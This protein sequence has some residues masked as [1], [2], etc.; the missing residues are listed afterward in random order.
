MFLSTRKSV[1]CTTVSLT[2]LHLLLWKV[3]TVVMKRWVLCL[4][5]G[6]L[7]SNGSFSSRATDTRCLLK[8]CSLWLKR[9]RLIPSLNFRISQRHFPFTASQV[10]LR[11]YMAFSS[12]HEIQKIPKILRY[13]AETSA[14]GKWTPTIEFI[15]FLLFQRQVHCICIA[16]CSPWNLI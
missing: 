15:L 7:N 16:C 13:S 1:M 4:D 6:V 11:N 9:S 10:L 5:A 2:D 14:G 12:R 8:G 3:Y